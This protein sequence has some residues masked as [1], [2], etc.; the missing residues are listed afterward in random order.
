MASDLHYGLHTTVRSLGL[1]TPL[2]AWATGST[3]LARQGTHGDGYWSLMMGLQSGG[4][5]DDYN[6]GDTV[7]DDAGDDNAP[8]LLL[9]F[10][11]PPCPAT[12]ATPQAKQAGT[13]EKRDH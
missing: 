9:L 12:T 4:D 13:I 8:L 6:D 7:D 11:S 2:E 5:G 10:F 1:V 3:E